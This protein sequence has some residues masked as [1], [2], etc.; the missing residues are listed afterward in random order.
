M[1]S[2]LNPHR[3][4]VIF[5]SLLLAA[6]AA[7]AQIPELGDGGPGPVK[8]QHLTAEI[9]SLGPGIAPGGTQQVGLVITLE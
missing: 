4:F 9:V 6:V 3:L 1:H 5:A 2:R 7:P 8:A